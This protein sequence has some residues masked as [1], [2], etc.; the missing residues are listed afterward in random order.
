MQ[1]GFVFAEYTSHAAAHGALKQLQ[2]GSA[3]ASQVLPERGGFLR[4][5]WAEPSQEVDAAIMSAVRILYVSNLP[6]ADVASEAALFQLFDDLAPHSVEKVKRIKGFAFVHFFARKDA[7]VALE[8]FDGARI[9]D[10]FIRI[11]WAK[12][13][14]GGG[15]GAPPR[16]PSLSGAPAYAAAL[17]AGAAGGGGAS[18]W[19]A[20]LQA[21]PQ[22]HEGGAG[23]HAAPPSAPSAL[24]LTQYQNNL[25]HYQSNQQQFSQQQFLQMGGSYPSANNSAAGPMFYAANAGYPAVPSFI[26]YDGAAMM[27]H[28]N[29]QH[30]APNYG[31][32]FYQHQMLQAAA[33]QAAGYPQ[34]DA[35]ERML[36]PHAV[37]PRAA[38]HFDDAEMTRPVSRE[39][40]HE[41]VAVSARAP[42][43]YSSVTAQVAT[44]A[45]EVSAAPTLEA[46]Q[47][48][49]KASLD[50]YNALAAKEGAPE[51][52]IETQRAAVS[53]TPSP[54]LAPTVSSRFIETLLD[55]NLDSSSALSSSH[56]EHEL[57]RAAAAKDRFNHE[58][59]L[60]AQASRTFV[61]MGL[62]HGPSLPL[63]KP[64]M[65]ISSSESLLTLDDANFKAKA[66]GFIFDAF[67]DS[68][69]LGLGH[70]PSRI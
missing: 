36:T 41:S 44:A 50:A 10:L 5:D 54:H 61:P 16:P 65:R 34:P 69:I 58:R 35:T 6:S 43:Q 47:A 59:D 17:A 45:R 3:H 70:G 23:M 57:K 32:V 26:P 38:A 55:T 19:S 12:P 62:G 46:V 2:R 49:V 18:Q 20:Q 56:L 64:I 40:S 25:T 66:P 11:Q 14:P 67:R 21:Q 9:G 63:P 68:N 8:R 51:L 24:T 33:H 53:A 48:L 1:R 13:P 4:A 22:T 27:M 42:D 31:M 37:S 29:M 30:F 28:P 7:E 39:L 52:V 15:G 60:Y